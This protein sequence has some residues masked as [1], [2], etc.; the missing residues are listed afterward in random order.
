LT[1]LTVAAACLAV[2][3]AQQKDKEAKV[4]VEIHLS[5][6]HAPKG[7][8]AG[9]RA[10]LSYVVSSVK[11]KSGKAIYNTKPL[12]EG[13]EVVAVK[14]QEKPADPAKAVL[15]E[16]NITKAQ[17]DKIDKVKATGVDVV[18]SDNGK[19][20]TKKRPIPLRLELLKPKKD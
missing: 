9:D 13:V 4:K 20:V 10:D 1:A 17:A 15:V 16:L 5:A 6:E 3:A 12:A 7:L 14:R 18:E 11:T 2:S 19:P 8:K